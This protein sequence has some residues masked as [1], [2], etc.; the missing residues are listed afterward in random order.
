ME[1]SSSAGRGPV[2]SWG[3]PAPADV[4]VVSSDESTRDGKGKRM[5]RGRSKG[6]TIDDSQESSK[7]PQR[8]RA[9]R[10]SLVTTVKKEK[11]G[12]SSSSGPAT[13]SKDVIDLTLDSSSDDEPP[14]LISRNQ[15]AGPSRSRISTGARSSQDGTEEAK[16]ST[17]RNKVEV[18]LSGRPR[19]SKRGNL[20]SNVYHLSDNGELVE[21]QDLRE[22]NRAPSPASSAGFEILD[23]PAASMAGPSRSGILRPAPLATPA[24][25][26]LRSGPVAGPSPA[27]DTVLSH[28]PSIPARP[29]P[30]I[31]LTAAGPASTLEPQSGPSNPNSPTIPVQ[32]V[33]D[34]PTCNP[35][36]EEPSFPLP[37]KKRHASK[38]TQAKPR[39]P[40]AHV[41]SWENP[42]P[43]IQPLGTWANPAP[44][45]PPAKVQRSASPV[46]RTTEKPPPPRLAKRSASPSQSAAG[47]AKTRRIEVVVLKKLGPS[48]AVSPSNNRP[49]LIDAPVSI[50]TPP[51]TSEP[52][53][54][55][56]KA[57]LLADPLVNLA[58]RT[59]AQ[60]KTTSDPIL[61][62]LDVSLVVE[63]STLPE[64]TTST[65][66]AS[67]ENG[68][69]LA[70]TTPALTEDLDM[71]L[72]KSTLQVSVLDAAIDRIP[73][74][75][76]DDLHSTEIT[77]GDA[78]SNAS[79]VE[80]KEEKDYV[81]FELPMWQGLN[82]LTQGA[83]TR[84]WLRQ[85][86]TRIKLTA[87]DRKTT[88]N[89]Q[90][91]RTSPR[92]VP[93]PAPIIS[94]LFTNGDSSKEELVIVNSGGEIVRP[95][96][97]RQY[98]QT[99][100][101]NKSTPMVAPHDDSP[102]PPG[103]EGVAKR[104]FDFRLIDEWNRN[105]GKYTHNP[106]LHA[107]IFEAYI[108]EAT[109]VDEPQADEIKVYNEV[110]HEGAPPDFE[111]AY[112]NQVLY[113]QDVP[114]PELGWIFHS[115]DQNVSPVKKLND[116]THI[117]AS[118][119]A[120][121]Y[122]LGFDKTPFRGLIFCQNHS[123]DPNVAISQA[124]VKD[125]EDDVLSQPSPAKLGK[126]K[127]KGKRS[128]PAQFAHVSEAKLI[129]NEQC[130]C[131]TRA[132]NGR[133]FK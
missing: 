46:P 79:V 89:G 22:D 16:R 121:S 83:S 75:S 54:Q 92:K 81:D 43:P 7:S 106:A 45:E 130:Y 131:G 100:M 115:L 68:L 40:A 14:P 99:A 58:R 51:A 20:I 123:C 8:S 3:N 97:F 74:A 133:M 13:R 12:P 102:P 15:R 44:F 56:L 71:P 50:A 39:R 5:G 114:D 111:F 26:H 32:Y 69:S 93:A 128:T 38:S 10:R 1:A 84:D 87:P 18:E 105:S 62:P 101:E 6:K 37:P 116:E 23:E 108:A 49:V 67:T 80:V 118:S 36:I 29:V 127:G 57:A 47:T 4:I 98:I 73:P 42:A 59:G 124:Y 78:E 19:S 95:T 88:Y 126:V 2:G 110:D 120:T 17:R 33:L 60:R 125:D 96:E 107:L 53:V 85:R 119:P 112:S 35:R 21:A 103:R 63:V 129:G 113:H 76:I 94:K 31:R 90:S 82:A 72:N 52:P 11:T 122:V 61:A 9:P 30:S 66:P 48:W 104:D 117:H 65:T 64:I 34:I 77:Q 55:E 70:V 132:C 86:S 27:P 109:S 28:H 41:G 24:G 91:P 25:D